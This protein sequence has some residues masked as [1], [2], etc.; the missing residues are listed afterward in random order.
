MLHACGGV[1]EDHECPYGR[2]LGRHS[3]CFWGASMA[4]APS[5]LPVP[6]QPEKPLDKLAVASLIEEF[7][8]DL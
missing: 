7:S 6:K 8:R 3:Q 1:H 2:D 5:A 4:Q